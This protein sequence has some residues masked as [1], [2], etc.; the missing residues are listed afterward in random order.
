MKAKRI[1]VMLVVF[2]AIAFVALQA[3]ST[4]RNAVMNGGQPERAHA[5]PREQ[6]DT[7]HARPHRLEPYDEQKADEA[8]KKAMAQ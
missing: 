6:P 2:A 7:Q 4:V 3:L 5:Q 8:M 1:L